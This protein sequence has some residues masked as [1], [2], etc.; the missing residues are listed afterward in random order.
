MSHPTSMRGDGAQRPCRHARSTTKDAHRTQNREV[1]PSRS[2]P[3]R[4]GC[5]GVLQAI[6]DGVIKAVYVI[7]PPGG[8]LS[9]AFN[10]ASS[11]IGAGILGLP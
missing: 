7:V 4:S 10:M 8:I 1:P 3:R 5:L 6:R 9:G 2:Q 11:S